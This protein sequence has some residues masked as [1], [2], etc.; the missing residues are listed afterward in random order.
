MEYSAKVHIKD[1]SNFY[2]IYT[3]NLDSKPKLILSKYSQNWL[4]DESMGDGILQKVNLI[5]VKTMGFT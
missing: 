1:V 4:L 3:Q 5:D 2:L